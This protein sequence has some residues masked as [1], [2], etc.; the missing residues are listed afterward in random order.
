MA[1]EM[2]TAPAPRLSVI[3]IT[4]NVI[5]RTPGRAIF[6]RVLESV[7]W[8]DEIVIVDSASTDETRAVAARYTSKIY[9][10]PFRN[11]LKRQKKIALEYVTG[12]WILWV[13][14]DEVL[15]PALIA[16]IRQA[17]HSP[18][19]AG[20]NAVN[21][22]MLRRQHIFAGLPLLHTGEDAKVRLWR[23]GVGHWDG[24]EN[25][26]IY[27]VPP[28]TPCF[29]TPLEHYSDPSLA[30]RLKKMAYFAPA[31]AAIAELPPSPHYTAADV[32]R[33]L[34]RPPLQLFYGVYWVHRGY[35]DGLRGFIWASLSAITEFYKHI[36]IWERAAVAA[37]PALAGR[38]ATPETGRSEAA[39]AA[40]DPH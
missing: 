31:H 26:D 13:D 29:N 8:A 18:A 21:A 3:M 37:A 1:I 40:S 10:H 2:D 25:D 6:E 22:F 11:S 35:R 30:A 16:E 20:P 32:W 24:P 7:A 4:G 12:D 9:V 19:I 38:S 14:A 28:P 34:L 36:L 5:V 39:A 33:R 15:P 27:V 17:L 23:R